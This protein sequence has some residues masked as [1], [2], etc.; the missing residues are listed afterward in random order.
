MLA[1]VAEGGVVNEVSKSRVKGGRGGEEGRMAERWAEGRGTATT[2]TGVGAGWGRV[3]MTQGPYI[4]Q[5]ALGHS[6]T[7]G[8]EFMYT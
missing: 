1:L 7:G 8:C 2:G 4:V 5:V 3:R 6:C